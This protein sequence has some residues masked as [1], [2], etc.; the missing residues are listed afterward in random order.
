MWETAVITKGGVALFNQWAAGGT[1]TID[2]ARAGSGVLPAE[3]L[4]TCTDL[5]KEQ[6]ILQIE[7][8]ATIDSGVK[9]KIIITPP[10]KHYVVNQIG[11]WGHLDDGES[12]LLALYQ[13]EHGIDV[14]AMTD[15]PE[16]RYEFYALV[17][18]DTTGDLQ[19]NV[20]PSLTVSPEE[21]EDRLTEHNAD[22]NAHGK[23]MLELVP[24]LV[25]QTIAQNGGVVCVEETLE[26]KASEWK[27]TGASGKYRYQLDVPCELSTE[28]HLTP[29]TLDEDSED[30]AVSC[31]M[32]ASASSF[33]GY[34]RFKAK[35]IPYADMHATVLLIGT[36]QSGSSDGSGYTLPVASPYILGGV[37]VQENSG[38]KIDREGNLAV[39]TPSDDDVRSGIEDTFDTP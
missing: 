5:V 20:T 39:D 38:L 22:P 24:A 33:D 16:F 12:T 30:V 6:Q 19:V 10:D 34:I 21:L 1:L 7:S 8:F 15:M 27:E 17:A 35:R 23:L 31:G 32:R 13:D 36:S 14:P 18:M 28:H 4:A 29:V 25:R 11:I 26:L 9:Y 3:Q 2:S 37:K